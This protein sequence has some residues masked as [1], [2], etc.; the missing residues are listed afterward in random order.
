MRFD[1][2]AKQAFIQGKKS[3][4]NEIFTNLVVTL[5]CCEDVECMLEK[6]GGSKMER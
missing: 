6:A 3:V 5:G 2:M 1:D 4:E